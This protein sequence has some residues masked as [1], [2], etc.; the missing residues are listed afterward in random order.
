M[1]FTYYSGVKYILARQEKLHQRSSRLVQG[2]ALK[3]HYH[4]SEFVD[5]P[6]TE[7]VHK[8]LMHPVEDPYEEEP[9]ARLLN[10]PDQV[11]RR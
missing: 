5:N 2:Q 6:E 11:S 3:R 9:E 4:G 8:S 1:L 7:L 10:G